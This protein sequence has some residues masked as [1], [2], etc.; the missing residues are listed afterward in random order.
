[1]SNYR[2]I[3]LLTTFSE[4]VGKVMLNR[5]YLQPNNIL[6]PEQ[7]GFRKGISTENVAFKLTD[8]IF[9]FINKKCMLVGYSV[10]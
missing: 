4:V 9:K 5:F 1:M 2:P 8:N 7:F 10:I 3:S 6:V